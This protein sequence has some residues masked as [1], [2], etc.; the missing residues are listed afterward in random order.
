MQGSEV[1][2]PCPTAGVRV[3][4]HVRFVVDKVLLGQV[5]LRVA[6][7]SPVSTIPPLLRTELNVETTL[8]QKDKRAMPGNLETKHCCLEYWRLLDR[9]VV[10]LVPGLRRPKVQLTL[11]T[12]EGLIFH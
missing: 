11:R 10:W 1:T 5:L 4:S 8:Y 12:V 7:L 6:L 2:L 9:K 3:Q